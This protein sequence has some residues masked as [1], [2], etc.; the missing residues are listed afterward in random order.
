MYANDVG[1]LSTSQIGLRRCLNKLE[2]YCKSWCIQVKLIRKK[3]VIFN[4]EP[5]ANVRNYKYLGVIF[6]CFRKLFYS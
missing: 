6:F 3:N 1:L 2:E 4:G 5:I